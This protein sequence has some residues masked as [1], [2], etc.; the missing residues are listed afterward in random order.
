MSR[1]APGVA[2]VEQLLDP[3]DAV[4]RGQTQRLHQPPEV[5]QFRHPAPGLPGVRSDGGRAAEVGAL[6]GARLGGERSS[7]RENPKTR[8]A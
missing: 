2:R 3:L 6:G 5:G 7:R 1:H 8:A 4:D